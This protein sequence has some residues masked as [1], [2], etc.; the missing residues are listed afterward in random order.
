MVSNASLICIV[1]NFNENIKMTQK[2]IKE[3]NK[4]F[5]DQISM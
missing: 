3:I 4:L 2:I 5:Q 1:M